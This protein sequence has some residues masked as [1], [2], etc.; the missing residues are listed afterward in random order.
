MHP[1]ECPGPKFRGFL[2]E[3][4]SDAFREQSSVAFFSLATASFGRVAT[5][6]NLV[7]GLLGSPR[8]LLLARDL[9]IFCEP[10][11]LLGHCVTLS[12]HF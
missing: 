12:P 3:M 10:P 5:V 6:W 1:S 9:L 2:N 8:N 7:G 4:S 11:P